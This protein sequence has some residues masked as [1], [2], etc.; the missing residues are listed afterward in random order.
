MVNSKSG[1]TVGKVAGRMG[2][3]LDRTAAVLLDGEGA[4]RRIRKNREHASRG[5]ARLRILGGTI[6]QV[7]LFVAVLG[8][9]AA[10]A[11]PSI[12]TSGN[13]DVQARIDCPLQLELDVF[14]VFVGLLL[15]PNCRF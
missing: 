6:G 13:A 9:A 5:C 11:A 15:K 7:A 2:G 1:L 3:G 8:A 14:G 4:S 10:A 12:T